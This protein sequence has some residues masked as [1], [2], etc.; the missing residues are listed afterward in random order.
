MIGKR[1]KRRFLLALCAGFA[2]LFAGLGVWQLERLRWKLDLIARVDARLAAEPVPLP[3]PA[4][5]SRLAGPGGEYRKVRVTGSFDHGRETLVE[6]LTERGPGFWVM[7]PL[8]TSQGTVLINR[9]FIPTHRREAASR[10]AGQ[11]SGS[12]TLVGLVRL[13][14]PK[15]RFLRTNQPAAERWYSRDVAAI[16]ARRGLGRVAPFFIDADDAPNPGGYP[17]G[18]LTVVSFRNAHLVY[19]LTWFGLA[20]L[21]LFGLAVTWKSTHIRE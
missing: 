19:A 3:G 17:V 16:A 10:A 6:A 2:L 12:Q 11:V 13:S 8:R 5:W 1:G 7:T 21:S 15:G 20:A 9:G 14:E 4:D 18:G